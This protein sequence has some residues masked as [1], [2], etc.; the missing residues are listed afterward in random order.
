MLRYDKGSIEI[1][2]ENSAKACLCLLNILP[3]YRTELGMRLFR[4][5]AAACQ[6]GDIAL[7]MSY[8]GFSS[9]FRVERAGKPYIRRI[10]PA[11]QGILS[12]FADI[13][14]PAIAEAVENGSVISFKEERGAEIE[15]RFQHGRCNIS[16]I[17]APPPP[18]IVEPKYV[19]VQKILTHGQTGANIRQSEVFPNFDAAKAAFQKEK[20][21]WRKRLLTMCDGAT[22]NDIEETCNNVVWVVA[23]DK[24]P[25]YTVSISIEFPEIAEKM[26]ANIHSERRNKNND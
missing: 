22:S 16:E 23:C 12:I 21:I 7:A 17:Q 14:L 15:Y 5:V 24:A 11:R 4:A 9:S 26:I 1:S 3:Q 18:P 25:G 6:D 10:A 13:V 8:L 19:L 20:D 2:A